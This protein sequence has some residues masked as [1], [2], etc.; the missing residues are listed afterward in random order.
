[1]VAAQVSTGETEIG[2]TRV[3]HSG[4]A[5]EAVL[6][7]LSE[8]MA[9]ALDTEFVIIAQQQP[10]SREVVYVVASYIDGR[11]GE[12][13]RL[14]VAGTPWQEAAATEVWVCAGDLATYG[15]LHP[16]LAGIPVASCLI[17][18]LRDGTSMPRGFIAV[19]SRRLFTNIEALSSSLKAYGRRVLAA[20]P[21]NEGGEVQL[22]ATLDATSRELT[23]L[24]TLIRTLDQDD[25]APLDEWLREV[26]DIVRR[27]WP[28]RHVAAVR[29]RLGSFVSTSGDLGENQGHHRLVFVTVNGDLGS[30]ELAHTMNAPV[31]RSEL[32][33]TI[34]AMLKRAV[35]RRHVA[36][37]WRHSEARYRSVVE[38]QSDMVCRYRADTTLTFVNYA[39]CRF[40]GKS[41]ESL[42]GVRF[43]NLIPEDDRPAA[44]AQIEALVRGDQPP[45]IEHAVT[46][47]D[48]SIGRHQWFNA[49]IVSPD[50]RI[51]E[52]QA[53]GRD[54]TDRWRAEEVLR[55]KEAR[56]RE[57]YQR[58][59]SLAQ[60]L[61]V[62]QEDERSG[63][64]RDLH[65]DIGQQLAAVTIELSAIEQRLKKR[66]D[67]AAAVVRVRRIASDLADKVRHTSHMLHPGVLK[68][69]G[70][71]AALASHCDTIVAQ[72]QVR[73]TF[74]PH[75][76]FDGVTNDIALCVYRVAQ[77][78]LH[79]V[80]THAHATQARVTLT[81]RDDTIELVVADNGRGF[82]PTKARAR[83]MGLMSI[84][85]RIN[86]AGGTMIIDSTEGGGSTLRVGL[87]LRPVSTPSSRSELTPLV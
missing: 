66:E 22:A 65:D 30:I 7:A 80:V 76:T 71:A 42:I 19:L 34:A 49:A 68:H 64:A 63:I 43:I 57:A 31:G 81:R 28:D 29:I 85:E 38:H 74:E 5:V 48:G 20:L 11:A 79:N 45:M 59:R 47:P 75:G 54:I 27:F 39:Y 3:A 67:V 78:A 61:I 50:G 40:F 56:L 86:L 32:L 9:S 23:L 24:R 69:A 51:E 25:R 44:M 14:L 21:G 37:A 87:P 46:R 26:A 17:V 4:I 82:D 36:Q 33:E 8:Q 60:R 12:T 70:L 84:E 1:M 16:Q 77:Q 55:T 53:I 6:S 18:C 73:V 72:H 83:G 62:V 13:A 2:E 58:I 10:P 41:R 52:F 15:S 35:N